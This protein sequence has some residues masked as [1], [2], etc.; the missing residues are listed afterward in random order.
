MPFGPGHPLFDPRPGFTPPQG[1]LGVPYRPPPITNAPKMRTRPMGLYQ[2]LT[3]QIA[4][5][6]RKR[7]TPEDYDYAQL[8]QQLPALPM[9]RTFLE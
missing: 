9:P 7:A 1:P 8:P 2:R 6:R 4:N 3:A 5:M